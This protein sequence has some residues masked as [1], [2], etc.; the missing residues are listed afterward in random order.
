MV[1]NERE[2]Y[3]TELK[4]RYLENFEDK[5]K[6]YIKY[7]FYNSSRLE[8]E[9][10]KDLSSFSH[11]Q[12]ANFL[13]ELNSKSRESLITYLSTAK[14]YM[15][16]AISEGYVESLINIADTFNKESVGKYVNKVA[17]KNRYI[18]REVYEDLINNLTNA[19]DQVIF[20]LLWEGLRGEGYCELVNLKE[21]DV[22][23]DKKLLYIHRNNDRIEHK[24]S[25]YTL[26][27][28]KDAIEEEEYQ[29]NNGYNEDLKTRT[30]PVSQT[31]YVIKPSGSKKVGKILQQNITSRLKKNA[32]WY[33]NPHLTGVSIHESGMVDYAK[34]LKEAK[35]CD[36]DRVDFENINERFGLNKNS[37][38]AT[39]FKIEKYI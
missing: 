11:N 16:Y 10:D 18:T 8:H 5:K 34:T 35:G 28:I 20:A 15:D 19:Q 9:Y 38:N 37:W 21:K 26:N 24:V 22:N 2:L 4:E 32:K 6:V 36:L 3:N 7:L 1:L 23:F 17:Q 13:I 27:I 31:E 14:Q 39:K 12:F 30:L 25:D 29:K 33:S